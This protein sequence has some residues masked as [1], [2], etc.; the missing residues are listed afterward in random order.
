MRRG[1]APGGS[2]IRI[3]HL[4]SRMKGSQPGENYDAAKQE[5]WNKE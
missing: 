5:V 3:E 2:G 4:Q 1:E